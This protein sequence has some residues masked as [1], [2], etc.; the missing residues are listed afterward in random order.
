M[1]YST[2]VAFDLETTGLSSKGGDEIVEI[3]AVKFTVYDD[4]GV[5]RPKKLGEFQTFVKPE[6]MIPD[7]ATRINHIT[8]AMVENAPPVR[9]AL[10]KFTGFCGQQAILVAHN[11]DFDSGFL[12][13]AYKNNPQLLPGNPIVDSLRI[14]KSIRP[15]LSSHKLGDLAHMFSRDRGQIK[16]NIDNSEMHRAVYDCEMLM[17]VFV[18]LLRSRLKEQD[19]ELGRTLDSIIRYGSAPAYLTKM[20]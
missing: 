18:A 4:G 20:K 19:W 14:A 17:E 9:D 3:G 5:I 7:S 10:R 11:A 15:E 1:I 13:V 16:L 2:F 12:H 6:R 8:N